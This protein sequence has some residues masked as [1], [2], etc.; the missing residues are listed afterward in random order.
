MVKFFAA[1]SIHS[2]RG[3]GRFLNDTAIKAAVGPIQKK[4]PLAASGP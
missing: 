2:G 3:L 4:E 1:T